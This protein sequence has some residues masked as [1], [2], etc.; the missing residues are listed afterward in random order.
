MT[1]LYMSLCLIKP[2]LGFGN[3]PSLIS[4][5][6]ACASVQ[7]VQFPVRGMCSEGISFLHVSSEESDQTG[8]SE[9]FAG[10]KAEI[11]G[12]SCSSLA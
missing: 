3:L 5:S 6:S 9:A 4:V 2:T 7:P 8:Q 1:G 10:S 12:F 11:I